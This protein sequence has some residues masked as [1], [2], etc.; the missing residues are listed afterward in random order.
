MGLKKDEALWT[1]DEDELPKSFLG[2]V[3]IHLIKTA[4]SVKCDA[5]V[6]YPVHVVWLNLIAK[7]RKYLVDHGHTSPGFLRTGSG[8]IE[9]DERDDGLQKN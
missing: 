2:L 5:L 8:R 3:R 6:A 4:F 9:I 7:R 1:V